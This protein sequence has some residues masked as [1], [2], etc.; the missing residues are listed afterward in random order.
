MRENRIS[1]GILLLPVL[2]LIL[3]SCYSNT[4]VLG[5]PVKDLPL[6]ERRLAAR[7]G[8][9]GPEEKA[10]L[11]AMTQV[12]QNEVFEEVEGVPEYRIGPSDVLEIK[13]HSGDQVETTTVTVDSRGRIT[14]SFIDDLKVAGLTPTELD[15]LLTKKLSNYVRRPRIDILVE[16]Y[17]SKSALLMGEFASLRQARYGGQ[18]ASGKTYLKGKTTLVDLIAQ[19]GGYTV[20]ADIRD[21]RLMR[22]G[23][24]YRINL[25][26]ILTKGE[27][28]MNVV[29]DDGDLVDIP[30]LPLYG[31]RVYVMGEVAYQGVYALEDAQDLLAAVALAGSFTRLAKEE[32][33]LIVRAHDPGEEPDVMMADLNAML[34][35]ADINQNIRLKDG[36]LVYVPRMR[37]G[38]INDWIKNTLPLLDI[39]LYPEEFES[40]YFYRKYLHLD[41]RPDELPSWYRPSR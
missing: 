23:K 33:T 2:A 16:E 25:Y 7:K 41:S 14:Y 35:Q 3:Q 12:D 22:E 30:E 27:E 26:D 21:V 24:S 17:H 40:R 11:K 29:I 37:I 6:S 15:E 10:E 20:N 8:R 39:L 18:A 1:I 34:R 19:A 32:N 13:W 31:E 5:T 38:D 28:E 9:L 36:D 4:A